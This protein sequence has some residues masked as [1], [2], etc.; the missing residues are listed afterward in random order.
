MRA[1]FVII[2]GQRCKKG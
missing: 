1:H 2:R